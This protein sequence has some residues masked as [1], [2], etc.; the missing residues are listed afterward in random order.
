MTHCPPTTQARETSG[1]ARGARRAADEW[2]GILARW[3]ATPA[4]P[5]AEFARL[6]WQTVVGAWPIE[7]ERL[8]A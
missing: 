4:V 1:P 3:A 2:A 8:R 6:L 7:R 5:D